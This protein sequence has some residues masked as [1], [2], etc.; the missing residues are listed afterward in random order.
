MRK[1]KGLLA[2]AMIMLIAGL[3]NVA[4]A[5]TQGEVFSLARKAALAA[6]R[7]VM[8]KVS[9][10]TGQDADYDIDYDSVIYDGYAREIQ[11]DVTLSWTAKEYMLFS[12]RN[13]CETWGKLY[14]D[15]SQ[16]TSRMKT[17]FI[18]KGSNSWFKKCADS[19]WADALARGVVIVV[20]N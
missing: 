10:N 3:A 6:A 14:I 8:G 2:A 12:S 18:S 16:G 4:S 17:R 15:L 7:D 5:Q 13:T 9:P 19:H 20:T 11:C 1:F